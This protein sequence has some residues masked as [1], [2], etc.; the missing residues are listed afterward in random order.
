M[1]HTDELNSRAANKHRGTVLHRQV[2]GSPVPNGNHSRISACV[3]VGVDLPVDK[4]MTRAAV[5]SVILWSLTT[6]VHLGADHGE[7]RNGLRQDH[8]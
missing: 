6:N 1:E 4:A 5:F 3:G 8:I 7:I 2:A